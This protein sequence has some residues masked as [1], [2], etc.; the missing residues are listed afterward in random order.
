MAS[1]NDAYVPNS[2][3]NSQQP[4]IFQQQ[5]PQFSIN[6]ST[7]SSSQYPFWNNNMRQL[8]MIKQQEDGGDIYKK[9]TIEA[10]G[11]K[12]AVSRLTLPFN[13]VLCPHNSIDTKTGS[14]LCTNCGIYLTK[15][16]QDKVHLDANCRHPDMY[17][18]RIQDKINNRIK[19]NC[20]QCGKNI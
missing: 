5:M 11:L 18:S 19:I 9:Y 4:S 7:S 16:Q 14:K 20:E 12:D 8:L 2:I 3:I 13:S 17:C 6:Q 1:L 10:N 15:S